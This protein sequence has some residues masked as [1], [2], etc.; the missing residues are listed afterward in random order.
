MI[1]TDME[2]VG[3]DGNRISTKYLRTMYSA[4]YR[5][6]TTRD[7][8]P[9]SKPLAELCPNLRA[10]TGDAAVYWGDIFSPMIMGNLV[11]TSTVLMRRDRLAKVIGFNEQLRHSGED[12]DFH[13]RTCREGPVAFADVSS[14]EYQVGRA[15]QLTQPAY[16]IHMANNFL[17]T[18]APVIDTDRARI[19]LPEAML[20][21]VQAEAH[22][23]I[24]REHLA[25]G[26]QR[27]ARAR[28]RT[29]LGYCLRQPNLWLLYALALCPPFVYR[30]LR[31]IVRGLKRLRRHHA[32]SPGAMS[33]L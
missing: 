10:S 11:H 12:Y 18:I 29:S 22:A 25:L 33:G 2:A 27:E 4:S 24:G 9:D 20:A 14:I 6:F 3:P 1:W 5:W 26:Q 31:A 28:F 23:W 30:S 21:Q 7:L 15:D 17:K 16:R 8:F 13:L 32:A 19:H